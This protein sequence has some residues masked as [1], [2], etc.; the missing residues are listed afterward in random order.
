MSQI[1]RTYRLRHFA[2]S[3]DPDYAR[4]LGVYVTNI[5]PDARTNSNE[6][7]YWLDRSYREYGD[8]FF[9]CGF[10]VDTKVVGY[11][12]GA[13]FRK[14]RVLLFDYL[15][16]HKDYRSHGEYFE[17]VRM[18]QDW[19]NSE[20]MEFDYA[21]AE[22]GFDSVTSTPSEH[23]LLLVSLF[24]QLGFLVA[25]CEYWQPTLGQDNP[26]SDMRA[27]LL[28]TT[29]EG[30][31]FI[32]RDALVN[33]IH[34]IYFQHN[35]RWYN[36]MLQDE[37]TRHT[38]SQRLKKRFDYIVESLKDR[39]EIRLDGVKLLNPPLPPSP[40]P[41][42]SRRT[43]FVRPLAAFF[44][45]GGFSTAFL[46]LQYYLRIRLDVTVAIMVASLIIFVALFTLYDKASL[47]TLRALLDA[48][49]RVFGK[50]R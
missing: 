17:F 50:R 35:E 6:I 18:L 16:L 2:S 26:Q 12:E 3:R 36:A 46:L 14:Q 33:I 45:I 25:E 39:D 30:A 13:F 42:A 22:V 44:A 32:C 19:I 7:T 41:R 38:Y 8:D 48:L 4:A 43:E 5:G 29:R 31:S 28:I 1:R 20:Q 49:P 11:A 9:V 27:H 15:V 34:T 10:Y 40:A 24:K 23:S 37:A 21:V 47:G